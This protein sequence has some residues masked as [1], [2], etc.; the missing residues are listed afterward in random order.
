MRD[1]I[2]MI[3]VL[4][5]LGALSGG[6]L[7]FVKTSTEEKIEY[8][9]LKFVK[10]P[11]IQEIMEGCSNDPIVD[12]FTIKDGEVER[13]FYVGVFDGKANGVCY[14][15]EG[16]GFGGAIGL[17]VGVNLETDE[18][19]GMGVTTH[20]ET[21]GLGARAKEDPSFRAQFKGMSLTEPFKVMT[22]GGQV[23]AVSGATIT[24]RGVCAGLTQSAEFYGRLKAQIIEEAAAF[25]N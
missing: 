6:G 21:P 4:A 16:K 13:S 5:L 22:D 15:G 7:A 23:D 2:K 3:V 14:E 24:S 11:A 17:M 12:R 18:L 19:L 20:S 1:I 9:Q 8:Q 10:G 25:A